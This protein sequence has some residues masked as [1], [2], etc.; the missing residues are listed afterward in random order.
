MR[1]G[2]QRLIYAILVNSSQIIEQQLATSEGLSLDATAAALPSQTS[3]RRPLL[4]R[5]ASGR[6]PPSVRR[7]VRRA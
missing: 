3:S 5:G 6:A 1:V 4:Q 7:R 2:L